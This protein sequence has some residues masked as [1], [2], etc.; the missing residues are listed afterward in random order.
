MR[1][2]ILLACTGILFFVVTSLAQLTENFSD[3]DY[4]ANP[5]WTSN[6]TDWI[7]NSA[8]QLQSN[9][10]VANSTFYISTVNTLATAMQWEFY[11]QLTFNTS[12]TNYTD[13]FLTASASDLS[14]AMTNGYF[15]RIGNTQDDICLYK[16]VGATS[17]KIIDG[18]DGT[19]NTSNNSIKVR[20]TRS[21][22]DQWI[23][24]RDL[25]GAGTTFFNEGSVTDNSLSTSA[26]FGVLVKQS[27]VA[28]FAQRHFFDDI[29][30]QPFA[31][32]ATPTSIVSATVIAANAVDILFT[33]ALDNSSSQLV[34]N[35]V[36]DNSLGSPATAVLDVTNRALIH[37]TFANNFTSTTN[38]LLTVNGVG[39]LAGN[40]MSNG[41]TNF[42]FTATPPVIQSAFAISNTRVDVLFNEPLE[43]TS[44]QLVTNYVANNSLGSPATAVLDPTN[45]ALVHLGFA[46]TFANGTIYQLTVND[47]KDLL[48]SPITN[49]TANFSFYTPG[50]YDVVIDEIMSDPTPQVGL[51]NAEWIELRNTTAF[52]INLQNWKIGDA[53]GISGAMPDFVLQPDSA[54]VICTA[55]SVPALAALG[56]TISV[57][58]FPSLDNIGEQLYLRDASG[59]LIHSVNYNVNWFQNELKKEGGWTLEMVD[60]KNPCSG[61]SNWKASVDLK[62]GTPGKINSVDA[63]NADQTAPKLLRAYATDSV[64]VTLVFDEP[65]D[66]MKAATVGSYSISDDI[67]VPAA[68]IAVAPGF[69]RVTLLLATTLARNK[70][71]TVTAAAIT[72]CMGNVIDTKNTAKVGLSEVA[73]CLNI[74]INEI[75]FNPPTTGNDYVEIYNRSNRIIDLRQTYIANR[76]TAGAISSIAQLSTEPYLLFPQEFMV[77]TANSGW[78]KRAYITLNPDAFITVGSMPSFNDDAGD[79]IILNAQGNITDELKYLDDWHFKLLDNREG[80]A[81][82]RIDYNA[83]T[84]SPENWH[85]AATSVNYGTPTYKN[86]QFH[87]NNGVQGEVK[88]TPEIV[89]PDNDGQDDFATVDYRFP[90]AGYVASITIFDANGRRVRYLQRNALCGTSGSFRWD[91]L[92]EKSQQLATGVY[93]V[94]TEVFN[95]KGKKKQ[96]KT[97]IVVARRN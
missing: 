23:L 1:K 78:V 8:G 43:N 29:S 27:T 45:R 83:P 7:V 91:G 92:G 62:G 81:L 24:Y 79:V 9:N 16:K 70:V 74:V 12:S 82:E 14:A 75:L 86:S 58:I 11:V 22:A 68:A 44:A 67:G 50:Q 71:Y 2:K 54:V 19:T 66:S 59:R 97:P 72:D 42:S 94:F 88:I 89:S 73:D 53:S 28:S 77:I 47:V 60:T 61:F 90:E 51:P 96:F 31:P 80:V 21:A 57:T 5:V 38:Y 33:E 56:T 87:I 13:V 34:T 95:L 65:L 41:T 49:G 84:Q 40:A 17:T 37:L 52:A 15:V 18:V 48:G 36:A 69:D 55:S 26:F 64:T 63:L 39:D 46:A 30:I 35:Y 85:S 93:V 3:G 20:V 32:D 6:A 25:T 4:T 76:N 10:I